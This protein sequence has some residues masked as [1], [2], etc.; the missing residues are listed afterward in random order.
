MKLRSTAKKALA[1][2]AAIGTG[3]LALSYPL[4][5]QAQ[6]NG[7]FYCETSGNYPA[8][9]RRAGNNEFTLISWES[10]YGAGAG[11]S[12]AR[13]CQIVTDKIN[14]NLRNDTLKYWVPGRAG[15]DAAAPGLPVVC[16]SRVNSEFTTCPSARILWTVQPG[17]NPNDVIAEILR[18]N[19]PAHNHPY[20]ANN[21]LEIY[22]GWN[23]INVSVFNRNL[24][25]HYRN[26]YSSPSVNNGESCA[27]T[28]LGTCR[29]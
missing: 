16:A 10:S 13:R 12:Q 11:Y 27:R 2:V 25:P 1:T 4:P 23:N 28:R 21:P 3:V 26:N 22:N 8:T 17:V 6:D 9:V 24:R 15:N 20:R 14:Q 18:F 29:Q 5:S 7:Y 19:D